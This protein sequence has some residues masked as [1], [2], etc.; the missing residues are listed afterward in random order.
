MKFADKFNSQMTFLFFSF[1][2][3]FVKVW[4]TVG[5][6]I[7]DLP[8]EHIIYILKKKFGYSTITVLTFEIIVALDLNYKFGI[9][10]IVSE[11]KS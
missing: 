6:C 2:L 1:F 8:K 5:S 7:L 11:F 4:C 3:F 9:V 10:E